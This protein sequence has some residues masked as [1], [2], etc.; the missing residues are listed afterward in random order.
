LA[1]S[2]CEVKRKYLIFAFGIFLAVILH[3]FYDFSIMT[4]NGYA[5]IIIPAVVI[6]TLA[7]LVYVGF[8]K[9]KKMKGIC[10]IKTL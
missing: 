6:L 2:L 7:F 8:E 5:K 10:K 4:L 3:G 9:L 1:I